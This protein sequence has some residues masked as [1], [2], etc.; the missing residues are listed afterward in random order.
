MK[1]LILLIFTLLLFSCKNDYLQDNKS[2]VNKE[3]ETTLEVLNKIDT[4]QMYYVVVDDNKLYVI[5]KQKVVQYK[6]TDN[7]LFV[8]L[9]IFM[10]IS[11]YV[12]L[13]LLLTKNI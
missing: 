11:F 8:K 10:A 13:M 1:N 2:L 9:F 3:K 12:V 6:V 4:T 7:S 5:D